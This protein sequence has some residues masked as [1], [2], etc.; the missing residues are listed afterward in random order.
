MTSDEHHKASEYL[1]TQITENEIKLKE[2]VREWFYTG[3][4]RIYDTVNKNINAYTAAKYKHYVFAAGVTT[5]D[6][7]QLSLS[8]TVPR[9]RANAI[10]LH[11]SNT[12]CNLIGE[13][14]KAQGHNLK[15][16][17]ACLEHPY[18]DHMP[19]YYR[20]SLP[21][22]NI[23]VCMPYEHLDVDVKCIFTFDSADKNKQK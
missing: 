9:D 19:P 8:S 22:D 1:N 15:N 17:N 18:L 10:I 12:Q 21:D 14:I 13:F 20:R 23:T 5:Y 7:T 6:P 11:E 2:K 16:V 3:K 4:Q